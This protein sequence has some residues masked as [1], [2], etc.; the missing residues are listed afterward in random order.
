MSFTNYGEILV[1]ER[2]P[3]S[4]TSLNGYSHLSKISESKLLA[5]GNGGLATYSNGQV[6]MIKVKDGI[7][8]VASYVVDGHQSYLHNVGTSILSST[9]YKMWKPLLDLP[10]SAATVIDATCLNSRTYLF[11]TTNGL[12]GTK[13]SFEM[14]NDVLPMTKDRA[15]SVYN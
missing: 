8:A 9:N 14:V 6:G 4:G 13:Y 12:Y 5:V 11:A 7:D 3:N 15:L 10:G 1:F 2:V